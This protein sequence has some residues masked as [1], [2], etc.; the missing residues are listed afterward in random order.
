MVDPPS[1][2]NA[3]IGQPT[4]NVIE[5]IISIYHLAMKFPIGNLVGKVRGDQAESQQCCA[6]STRVAE[7]HKMVNTIFHLEDVETPAPEKISH[8]FGELDPP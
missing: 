6:M 4:L 7:K 5:A 2:Y 1:A 8:A 3:I